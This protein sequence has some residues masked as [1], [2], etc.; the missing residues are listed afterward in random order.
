MS[1]L[2]ETIPRGTS[3]LEGFSVPTELGRRRLISPRELPPIRPPRRVLPLLFRRQAGTGPL[4]VGVGL[5]PVH[6]V[7][8][9]VGALGRRSVAGQAADDRA[10]A[11]AHARRVRR[12]RDLGLLHAERSDSNRVQRVL[13]FLALGVGGSHPERS[14]GYPNVVGWASSAAVR[15]AP[16]PAGLGRRAYA[17]EK[18]APAAVRCRAAGLSFR[19]RGDGSAG[20]RR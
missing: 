19:A 5:I 7:D 9:V 4:A 12:H 1:P 2:W 10:R 14:C 18:P 13:V 3:P 17:A 11:G 20:R 16:A 6:A 8:W 15:R